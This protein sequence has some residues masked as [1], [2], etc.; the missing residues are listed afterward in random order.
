MVYTA[1]YLNDDLNYSMILHD[2]LHEIHEP[3]IL[4]KSHM[5]CFPLH[6]HHRSC[7]QDPFFP[8]NTKY[9]CYSSASIIVPH[10][11]ILL[12]IRMLK[13]TSVVQII[14][15]LPRPRCPG[16]VS[17]NIYCYSDRTF[18]FNLAEAAIY[19]SCKNRKQKSVTAL[20]IFSVLQSALRLPQR[21]GSYPYCSP[22]RTGSASRT[23]S[24]RTSGYNASKVS[25][26]RQDHR[27][28]LQ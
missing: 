8:D 26:H 21:S 3:C 25:L 13:S 2:Y 27:R 22:D 24:P 10:N 9:I 14:R 23:R 16:K 7:L 12:Y 4:Y 17:Y 28:S 20:T 15:D 18:I 5:F 11:V 1:W 19:D 6:R